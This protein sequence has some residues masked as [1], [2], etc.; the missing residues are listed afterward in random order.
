VPAP[1]GPVP[2]FNHSVIW[3]IPASVHALPEHAQAAREAGCDVVITKPCLPDQL[4][5]TI[6]RILDG[7]KAKAKGGR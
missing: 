2:P 6:R 3:D 7:P 4:L 1:E 5:E